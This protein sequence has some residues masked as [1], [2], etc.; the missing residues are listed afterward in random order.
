MKQ[1]SAKTLGVAALGAA[2]AAT[3]AGSAVAAPALPDAAGAL[4]TVTSALPVDQAAM[5]LPPGAPEALKAGQDALGKSAATAPASATQALP[6]GGDKADPV[7]GLL[8]G[9]PAKGLPTG[10]L[11][12]S[13]LP[14]GG[15]PGLGG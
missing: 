5:V 9:L 11:P 8:G 15:L 6:T 1:L 10:S 13:G 3:A 2:F 14:T 12:T 7:S 4:G